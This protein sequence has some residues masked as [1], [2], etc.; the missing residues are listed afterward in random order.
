MLRSICMETS[1]IILFVIVVLLVWTDRG[2]AV[3]SSIVS[4]LYD[5]VS[6]IDYI[7]IDSKK[8]THICLA[9]FGV[10]LYCSDRSS[11]L[12]MSAEIKFR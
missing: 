8:N 6:M 3:V 1:M 9:L 7:Y 11:W 5:Y 12:M 2:M 10:L 4:D